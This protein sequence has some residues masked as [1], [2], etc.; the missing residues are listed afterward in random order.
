MSRAFGTRL[1]ASW[2]KTTQASLYPV[3]P[4]MR[5]IEGTKSERNLNGSSLQYLFNAAM[6]FDPTSP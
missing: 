4:A 5:R 1:S 3:A 2:S 6:S